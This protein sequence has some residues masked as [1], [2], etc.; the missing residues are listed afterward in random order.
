MNQ[1]RLKKL[2]ISE[3]AFL[4]ESNEES[5]SM[6]LGTIA[7]Q[8]VLEPNNPVLVYPGRRAGKEW[9]A[10]LQANEGKTICIQS[11]YDASAGIAESLKTCVFLQDLLTGNYETE[12]HRIFTRNG[13]E[14]KALYD[15]VNHD[16]KIIVDLK[17]AR[18][19][20]LER[21]QSASFRYGYH[22]QD[23]FYRSGFNYEYDMYFVV[24]ESKSP[25]DYG[26]FQ[27]DDD[28]R[29]YAR[30]EVNG[31]L[32]KS[33]HV[34]KK[35]LSEAEGMYPNNGEPMPVSFPKWKAHEL[36]NEDENDNLDLDW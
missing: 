30:M 15:M 1:S 8:M 2:L 25:F 27:I 3:K 13:V 33:V 19:I 11:E 34:L 5:K 35:D 22:L 4:T 26:V 29:E 10:Y 32:E 21:Y 7:H 6:K 36:L 20:E 31:L 28:L 24:V 16:K 18:E 12:T 23:D 9:E 14:C 17:T